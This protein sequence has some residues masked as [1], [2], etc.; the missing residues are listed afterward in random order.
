MKKN[1][2]QD[3]QVLRSEFINQKVELP[4]IIGAVY[5]LADYIQDNINK[6]DAVVD[7][8]EEMLIKGLQSQLDV[9]KQHAL[10]STLDKEERAKFYDEMAAIN[11]K[12]ETRINQ[13]NA[14]KKEEKNKIMKWGVVVVTVLAGLF[15]ACKVNNPSKVA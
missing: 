12:I 11:S 14:E 4:T 10:N 2:Q 8:N 3:L 6:L 9:A 7:K 1:S 15:V 13:I 5:K